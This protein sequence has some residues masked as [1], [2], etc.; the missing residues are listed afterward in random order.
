MRFKLA[1]MCAALLIAALGPESRILAQEAASDSESPALN[2]A[3]AAL[4]IGD[5]PDGFDWEDQSRITG[6]RRSNMAWPSIRVL[7]AWMGHLSLSLWSW[8]PTE[9]PQKPI[10]MQ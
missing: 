2:L 6:G 4:S 10:W 8:R 3:A 1:A 9:V 7:R 5:L